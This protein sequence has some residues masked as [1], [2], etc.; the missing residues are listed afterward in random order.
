MDRLCEAAIRRPAVADQHAVK[1]RPQHGGRFFEA[2]PGLDRVDR[3]VRRGETPQP[4]Q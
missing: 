3:R 1:V 2:A 4:F